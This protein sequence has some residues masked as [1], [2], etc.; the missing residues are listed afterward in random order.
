[1]ICHLND[2]TVLRI[3]NSLA[4]FSF[5]A[6]L[7]FIKLIQASSNTKM[8]I[9]LNNAKHNGYYLLLYFTLF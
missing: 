8:P 6:V 5:I 7:R 9:M 3:P 2:P 4:L 1:M